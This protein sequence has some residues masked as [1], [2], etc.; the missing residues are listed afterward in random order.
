MGQINSSVTRSMSA[1]N[2]SGRILAIGALCA[3]IFVQCGL[4]AA[5][6]LQ[7]TSAG[8]HQAEAQGYSAEYPADTDARVEECFE[9]SLVSGAKDC[10]ED[11]VGASREAQ[12][13]EKN[14]SAQQD[15]AQWAWWLLIVSILQVPIGLGGL[16]AL[17]ASLAQGREALERARQANEVTRSAMVADT[18]AWITVDVQATGPLNLTR[19]IASMTV[20]VVVKNIGNSVALHVRTH[21]YV[22]TYDPANHGDDGILQ[23]TNWGTFGS[24]FSS[25]IFPDRDLT[26]PTQ[27]MGI[28]LNRYVEKF[29]Q[30]SKGKEP[31][32]V[33]LFLIAVAQ[34]KLMS[35]GPNTPPRETEAIREICSNGQ[36]RFPLDSGNHRIRLEISNLGSGNVT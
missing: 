6:Y 34:Y 29:K 17:L 1:N 5:L 35:D 18:R 30:I 11:A 31:D 22:C 32:G 15:M 26:R 21:A 23:R 27:A 12:R 8:R 20:E 19:D 33:P 4:L 13:S 36:N 14:L 24:Q 7:G 25:H 2:S 10:V 9:Q 28:A 3:A 16:L